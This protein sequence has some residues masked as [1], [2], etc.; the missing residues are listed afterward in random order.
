MPEN[1]VWWTDRT[2]MVGIVDHTDG[3]QEWTSQY[4]VERKGQITPTVLIDGLFMAVNPSNLEHYFDEDFK[5]FHH[6]DTSFC[7]PNYL[8][9]CNIGVTTD[10]RILHKSVG[11]TNQQWEESRKQLAEKYK[12]ELPISVLPDFEDFDIELTSKPKVTVIIPTKNNLKYI[13]NNINSWNNVVEYDNYEIIIADTGSQPEV[14]ETYKS[15]LNSR[16]KLIK[17]NY[18]NFAKINNDVVKNHV[19]D[20][21]ELLLFCNDDIVLLNDA[22]SRCVQIYNENKDTVGT[23]GIRL[24]Y[25]DSSIQ[26]NGITLSMNDDRL[27]ISHK[28]IKKI[29]N[30]STDV[31]YNSIGNTGGFLLIK[32]KLFKSFDGFNEDYIECLEDVEL[33]LRCK[34]LGLKNIT[35]SD[36]VAIHYESISRNKISGGNERFVEDYKKLLV[37]INENNINL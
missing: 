27:M 14:F 11:Q 17:Y 21:T 36:A 4:S 23:I 8:D 16:I 10:I 3:I 24:H 32:K 19:S 9:G 15:L 29:N 7:L 6:Y 28:D 1:G 5:G 26:H 12:D 22:L 25:G 30:Y 31:N 33:N 35:V 18:Y 34:S 13:I 20:D 37:F 2:K